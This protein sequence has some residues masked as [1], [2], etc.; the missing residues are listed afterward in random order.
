MSVIRMCLWSIDRCSPSPLKRPLGT[1]CKRYQRAASTNGMSLKCA[2]VIFFLNWNIF[3]AGYPPA[4][5]SAVVVHLVAS[6]EVFRVVV[7]LPINTTHRLAVI[8]ECLRACMF[9]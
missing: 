3:S 8:H 5:E 6:R 1:P 4:V 2:H 7:L 9:S